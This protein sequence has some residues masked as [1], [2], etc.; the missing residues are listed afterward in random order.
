M[1]VA[2]EFAEGMKPS[3]RSDIPTQAGDVEGEEA[4][5]DLPVE[6]STLVVT[7]YLHDGHL[8]DFWLAYHPHYSKVVIKVIYTFNH[9]CWNPE[10]DDYVPYKNIIKEAT[11]E[12]SFYLGPLKD[13]QGRVVPEYFVLY[14]SGEDDR[15]LAILLEYG[16]QSIGEGY[17][18]MHKD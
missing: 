11:R 6:T 4:I 10:L 17:V 3:A 15:Y 1:S 8:W 5:Q 7:Q 2:I 18:E 14:S 13:L 16:G 12:E 9:P